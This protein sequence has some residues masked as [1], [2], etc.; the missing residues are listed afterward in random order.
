MLTN[1]DRCSQVG[2]ADRAV[3]SKYAAGFAWRLQ[4]IAMKEKDEER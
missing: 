2:H 4:E 1:A 3:L